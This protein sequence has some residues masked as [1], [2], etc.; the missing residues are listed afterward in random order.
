MKECT[1]A[2]PTTAT[3][4]GGGGGEDADA[5]RLG[6]GLVGVSAGAG[7]GAGAG[8]NGGGAGDKC[9]RGAVI[10]SVPGPKSRV[11]APAARQK[12][13][14]QNKAKQARHGSWVVSLLLY[15]DSLWDSGYCS[16][17]RIPP[18]R[19]SGRAPA[20]GG[21]YGVEDVRMVMIRMSRASI[22]IS[23]LLVL[24]VYSL[25]ELQ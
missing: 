24:F 16:S 4:A 1:T 14:I 19:V 15:L 6:G 3:A 2:A 22:I 18:P 9:G 20:V 25:F 5:G 13:R 23:I 8:D 11:L 21:L 7:A 12:K 10:F 17:G